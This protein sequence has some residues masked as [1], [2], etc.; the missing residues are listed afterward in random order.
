LVNQPSFWLDEPKPGGVEWRRVAVIAQ[1][2]PGIDDELRMLIGQFPTM[3][4][5]FVGD[6][7]QG[8][9]QHWNSD[10]V[11]RARSEALAGSVITFWTKDESKKIRR[12]THTSTELLSEAEDALQIKQHSAYFPSSSLDNQAS[13]NRRD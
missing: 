12:F 7:E 1:Q 6:A 4:G 3:A 5:G 13:H 2:I 9:A 8:E 11:L 10:F